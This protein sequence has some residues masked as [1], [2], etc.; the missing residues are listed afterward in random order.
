[1]RLLTAEYARDRLAQAPPG[2]ES[3]AK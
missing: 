1:V 3:V 2:L